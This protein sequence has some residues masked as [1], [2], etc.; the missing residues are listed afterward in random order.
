MADALLSR[1]ELVALTDIRVPYAYPY[2]LRWPEGSASTQR[3]D[4]ARWL[5]GEVAAYCA[6]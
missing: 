2:W 5:A 1:G 6:T 3:E 4:F